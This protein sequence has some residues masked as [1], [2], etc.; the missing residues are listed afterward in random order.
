MAIDQ[1]A[2]PTDHLELRAEVEFLARRAGL[3]DLAPHHLDQMV[4]AYPHVQ[5]MI[6]RL[7]RGRERGDEPAH[8]FSAGRFE[9]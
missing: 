4:D 8:A 6:S 2:Q 5:A 9:D 1:T 3:G 7:R